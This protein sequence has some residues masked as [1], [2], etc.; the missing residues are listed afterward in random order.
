MAFDVVVKGGHVL[1]PA[2][3][4]DALLDVGV[5]DGKIAAV[6]PNLDA[7]GAQAI[8]AR[9]KLVSPGFIDP[10]VHVFGG[11]GLVDPDTVGVHQGVTTLADF[12]GAGTA[13]FPSFQE[14]VLPRAKTSIYSIVCITAGGVGAYGFGTF[15]QLQLERLDLRQFFRLVDAN[16]D[17]IKG[18]KSMVSVVLGEEFLALAKSIAYSAG[19]PFVLH[20]GEFDDYVK[21]RPGEYQLITPAVLDKLEPGDIITHC[22]T[23][24]PGRLFGEDGT[25]QPG[26]REAVERGVLLDLGH[27]NHGFDIGVMRH[28]LA[29][30][31]LP[32]TLGT[33]LHVSSVSPVMRSL[34]DVMSKLLAVGVELREVVR[35]VTANAAHLL[36]IADRAGTLRPGYPAD[37]TVFAVEEGEYDWMDAHRNHFPG[38]R[39][40]VPHGCLK[41]G[42]WYP[43]Q[44]ALVDTRDNRSVAVKEDVPPATASLSA[45]QRE[46]LAA[47]AEVL[48]QRERWD[49]VQLH[50]AIEARREQLGLGLR[51][52]LYALHLSFFGK[53]AGQ[54]AA[55][56]LARAKRPFVLERLE[57]VARAPSAA[58]VA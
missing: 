9:G 52:A 33:D 13:T 37:V 32:F 28:G 2:A 25:P 24:E 18:L 49:Q 21:Y 31:I 11:I 27:S 19:L 6:A 41:D 36:Q 39:R 14:L 55:W 35:M 58:Q 1:D 22:Y 7:T 46:Y 53:P 26:V 3:G 15:D 54:Q 47:V 4:I 40:V 29:H 30:G 42:V 48:R 50:Y 17:R 56:F 12:G 51:E 23:P 20:L 38:R 8:D 43:A 5:R 16:R 10:H 57:T 34:A 45:A 44:M